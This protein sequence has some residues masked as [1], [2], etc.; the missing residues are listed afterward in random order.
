[1]PSLRRTLSTPSVRSAPYSLLSPTTAGPRTHGSGHRRSTGS[2][3]SGR[4][5]LADIEWWR[6]ADG[7]RDVVSEQDLEEADLDPDQEE[8]LPLAQVAAVPTPGG[9]A[10]V[11]RPSTPVHWVSRPQEV[12]FFSRVSKSKGSIYARCPWTKWPRSLSPLLP[13][14][15][16]RSSPRRLRWSRRPRRRMSRRSIRTWTLPC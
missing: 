9:A 6:V 12:A 16:T 4:R 14:V 10:G 1:M 3:T 13:R 11:E 2:E 15:G 8:D 5:I 7:Q